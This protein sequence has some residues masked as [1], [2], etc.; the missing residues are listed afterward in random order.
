MFWHKYRIPLAA[1]CLTLCCFV[2]IGVGRADRLEQ[3][4]PPNQPA[5]PGDDK[6][7]PANADAAK[8]ES[9]LKER[10]DNLQK[11]FD[12]LWNRKDLQDLAST[13]E[14]MI[15]FQD[16]LL[17]VKLELA[18]SPQQRMEAFERALEKAKEL[19]RNVSN[20][21]GGGLQQPQDSC[22]TKESVL[23]IEI[24]MFKEKMRRQGK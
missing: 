8:L 5:A 19:D 2:A 15:S 3:T 22:R 12:L 10:R 1:A 21:V 18:R 13:L 4:P 24:A 20:R 17:D 23:K 16:R 6:P 7:A 11:G 9:L 14:E